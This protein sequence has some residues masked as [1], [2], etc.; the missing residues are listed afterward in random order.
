MAARAG[1]PPL[2]NLLYDEKDELY[3]IELGKTRD[4]KYPD[5]RHRGQRHHRDAL[6]AGRPSRRRV[7][8]GVPPRRKG[9]RY[10]IDHREDLF[11]I[12]TDRD[13]VNFSVVTAPDADPS[14]RNW[15]VWLAHR[16]DVL[17]NDHRPIP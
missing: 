16:K 9:H 1:Q 2:S 5:A 11:Y 15:K 14:E 6:P 10:Y 4:R 8:P 3:D 17:I 12:R 13:G 7:R